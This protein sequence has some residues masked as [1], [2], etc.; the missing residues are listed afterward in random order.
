MGVIDNVMQAANHNL[1]HMAN[2]L[3]RIIHE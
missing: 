1:S 2:T 3:A